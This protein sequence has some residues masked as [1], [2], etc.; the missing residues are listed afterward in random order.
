MKEQT[1]QF[2]REEYLEICREMFDFVLKSASRY[3]IDHPDEAYSEIL[4][5]RTLFSYLLR[6]GCYECTTYPAEAEEFTA[7]ADRDFQSA[8]EKYKDIIPEI[9]SQNYRTVTQWN[10]EYA[11]GMSLHWSDPHPDLAPNWCI[12]H[13]WNGKRPGSFLQDK[14]YFAECFMRIMEEARAKYP[15]YDTLY[16]FSWL[17]SEPRFQEFF[18]QEWRDNMTEGVDFI[19]ANLG[20][21]GQFL[22][23][24]MSLN[25]KT[26]AQYLASGKLPFAPRSSHCSFEAMKKHLTDNILK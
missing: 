26:T 15:Q 25:R 3:K 19:A 8:C 18:P 20:F 13:M 9:A 14:R 21:L 23:S 7:E 16:T 11:P 17:L 5:K 22:T 6:E 4:K 10:E 1:M 2:T 12:F 24:K